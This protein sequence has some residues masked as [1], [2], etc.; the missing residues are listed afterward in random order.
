MNPVQFSLNL[1]CNLSSKSALVWLL[2]A[3]FCLLLPAP[4]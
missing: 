2:G 4:R 3:V 1:C